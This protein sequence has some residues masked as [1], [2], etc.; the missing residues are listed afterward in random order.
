MFRAPAVAR[1]EA[2]DGRQRRDRPGLGLRRRSVRG[3]R[4]PVSAER[5]GPNHLFRRPLRQRRQDAVGRARAGRPRAPRRRFRPDLGLR[6]DRRC[7]PHHGRSPAARARTRRFGDPGLDGGSPVRR[8]DRAG[9]RRSGRLWRLFHSGPRELRHGQ[10]ERGLRFDGQGRPDGAD[11]EPGR[12]T[13][14]AGVRLWR[15]RSVG[16]CRDQAA[17]LIRLRAS[18]AKAAGASSA[19]SDQSRSGPGAWA[20]ANMA[21]SSAAEATLA[22]TRST[23]SREKA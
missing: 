6:L 11:R 21:R 4:D 10:S 5:R 22:T 9:G 12:R 13:L 17:L 7:G 16:L 23:A 19:S 1:A 14:S 2:G 18:A 15:A 3:T 20:A 8:P